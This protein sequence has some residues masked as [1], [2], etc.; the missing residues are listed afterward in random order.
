VAATLIPVVVMAVAS[1][2]TLAVAMATPTML[3]DSILFM[4]FLDYPTIV[5]IVDVLLV[6]DEVAASSTLIM[7][8]AVPA[9]LL[10]IRLH[11]EGSSL[12]TLGVFG[13]GF[14]GK[15]LRQVVHEEPPLLGLGASIGDLEEPDYGSQ[16]MIHRQL[17]L[18]L[19]VGDT[20]G[21]RGNNLLAGDPWDLVPHLAEVL[22]VL[23]KRFTLVLMHCLEIVLRGGALVLGHEVSDKLSAQILP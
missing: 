21:E 10:M 9:M 5:S 19:D 12:L 4:Q 3:G 13:L 2:I 17:F 16:L 7:L 15:R 20:R 14:W 23:A 11:R 22:D 18:H 8:R 1:R 6:E